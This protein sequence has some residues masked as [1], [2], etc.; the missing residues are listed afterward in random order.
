MDQRKA[1]GRGLTSL[2]PS[3][4]KSDATSKKFMEIPLEDIITNPNQPRKLFAKESIDELALSIEEKGIIQPLIVRPIGGGKY[5]LI[6]GERRYRAAK[7]IGLEKA[8]A[9]I[10]DIGE[11]ETLE[12]ALIENIQ[13]E[14]LNVVEEALAYKDLL[15]KFQYTQ[16]EL[17][18]RLGKDRSSIANSLRLLKLPDKIRNHLINNELTM[19]HA[20][21]LLAIDDKDTQIQVAQDIIGN[22]LSVR[23][24]ENLIKKF[25]N[26][27]TSENEDERQEAVRTAAK[28][29]THNEMVGLETRIKERLRSFVKIKGD[30]A[31]GK[32]TISYESEDEL[33]TICDRLLK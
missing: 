4:G 8:P 17:A 10:K 7:Q 1:L 11:N 2:I 5:E 32:I 14:N 6:A 18:K 26:S 12:I 23:E 21:A 24:T 13:R 30:N 20:R 16:D 15:S 27:F 22:S 28:E 31:K 25:K 9:V 3:S 29:M 19:G 33:N